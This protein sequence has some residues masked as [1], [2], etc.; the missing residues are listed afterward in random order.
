MMSAIVK[1]I[2]IM[3]VYLGIGKRR[4]DLS[5]G[6]SSVEIGDGFSCLSIVNNSNSGIISCNLEGVDGTANKIFNCIECGW[7]DRVG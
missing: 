2:T 6:G 7:M 4:N 5:M 3:S 1:L